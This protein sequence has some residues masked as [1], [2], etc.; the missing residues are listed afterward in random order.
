MKA[1]IVTGASGF[2]GSRLV[3][4]LLQKGWHV[5]AL[6]RG[7]RNRPWDQRMIGALDDI[8]GIAVDRSLLSSLHCHEVN[9]M[10]PGLGTIPRLPSRNYSRSDVV[11]FHVAGDTRFNPS[12]PEVQRQINVGASLNVLRCFSDSIAQAVHV[13]TAYVAGNREGLVLEGEL[14]AGQAFRNPYEQSKFEAEQAVTQWCGEAGL[15]LAIVRPSIITNDTRTGRSST[16]THLNAMV[17]VI[18]R[19]QEHFGIHDGQVVSEQIRILVNP[20]CRPNMA[21]VDPIVTSLA[22]IGITPL[23]AGRTYHL[24]HPKPQTNA[25]VISLVA[26]A[27]DV[28]GKITVSFASELQ[29]PI[30][31]TERM[32]ARSFKLYSPYMNEFCDFDLTNTRSLIP[33]YDSRFPAITLEYLE[34]V[35]DFWRS[36]GVK[37][38]PA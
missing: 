18:S 26:E 37:I 35:I 21:P 36:R 20:D 27:F 9:L 30:T 16:L 34:K 24:C 10:Q 12:D 4:N 33:D 8:S 7:Q 31:W 17:E 13:S 5:H 29:E 32:V 28:Q 19:I 2:I 6:G 11:L 23:A 1:A 14:D 15:P 38:E 3:I 25:E 22:E